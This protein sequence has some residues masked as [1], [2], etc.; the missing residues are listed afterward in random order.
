MSASN[1][2]PSGT[3]AENF[4][5]LEVITALNHV[6][7]GALTPATLVSQLEVGKGFNTCR[8]QLP[9]GVCTVSGAS[10][11][12]FTFANNPLFAIDSSVALSR[13]IGF[14]H[15]INYT[16]GVVQMVGCTLLATSPTIQVRT[17]N[18]TLTNTNTYHCELLIQYPRA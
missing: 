15:F 5:N 14:C 4:R 8:I 10:H 9:D 6:G 16:T 18:I 3:T 7:F 12:A 1:L 13:C 2:Y 17:D 11:I